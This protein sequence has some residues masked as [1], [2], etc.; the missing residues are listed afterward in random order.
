MLLGGGVVAFYVT[1]PSVSGEITV[2]RRT[3]QAERCT[4]FAGG[5]QIF[6]NDEHYETITAGTRED[7]SLRLTYGGEDVTS[8]T[9]DSVFEFSEGTQGRERRPVI[10][11]HM[12]FDCTLRDE[13]LHGS[14][15]FARCRQ[16]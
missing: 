1:S 8:C 6:L 14:F 12:H 9:P 7:G 13:R 2:G 3:M 16:D 11:G 5:V 10:G 4:G 15:D